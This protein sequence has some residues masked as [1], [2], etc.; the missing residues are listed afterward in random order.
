[1]EMNN[2]GISTNASRASFGTVNGTETTAA[3]Q[4]KPTAH[5]T[6]NLT[7]RSA[8]PSAPGEVPAIDFPDE[9]AARND[10]LGQ[11]VSAAFSLPPPPPPNFL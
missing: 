4:Q 9:A 5:H 1:M 6:E 3:A 2:I 11:L 10:R 7:I 8:G